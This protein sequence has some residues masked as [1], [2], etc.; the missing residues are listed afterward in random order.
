[1]THADYQNLGTLPFRLFREQLYRVHKM[2]RRAGLMMDILLTP[3]VAYLEDLSDKEVY[4]ELFDGIRR[5]ISLESLRRV[6]VA[7]YEELPA[8][9]F[10]KG[11]LNR[12][13]HI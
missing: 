5:M 4:G 3:G 6:G 13:M 10:R 9:E 8:M 7:E 11:P 12:E 1:M 2:A